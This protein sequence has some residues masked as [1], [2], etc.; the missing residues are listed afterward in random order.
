MRKELLKEL[1]REEP[2]LLKPLFKLS[3]FLINTYGIFLKFFLQLNGGYW[4][5]IGLTQYR[6]ENKIK[7]RNLYIL[8]FYILLAL[9]FGLLSVLY[10][11]FV[12]AY[13]PISIEY[14]LTDNLQWNGNISGIIAFASFFGWLYILVETK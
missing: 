7:K 3:R 9:L 13:V 1:L 5:R 6:T 2:V 10:W 11:Y 12:I 14:F 8:P 4:A